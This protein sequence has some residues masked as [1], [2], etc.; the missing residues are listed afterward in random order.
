MEK[1]LLIDGHSILNRAY[2]GIPTLTNKDGLH[3]NA[4]YGFLNILF[5]ILDE[6]K[7]EYLTVCF[8]VH[9]P[10]FRHEMFP[11][12]K[13]NRKGMD[14]ELREQVPVIQELLRAMTVDVKTLEGYE[15]DDIIGTLSKQAEDKGFSVS[16]VSG[17]RDLLQLT[18]NTTKL[19]IPKTKRSGTEIEEYFEKDVIEKY[20]VTP[21]EF[22]DV[23]AL[24]GDSS[25]N[26]PGVAGIGEKGAQTLISEYHSIENA[27]EHLEEIKQKRTREALRENY[28]MGL[29]CKKLAAINRTS[30]V[31]FNEKESLIGDFYTPEAFEIIKRL[32]FKKLLERFSGN[33]TNP[34]EDKVRNVKQM[35]EISA[36][37]GEVFVNLIK[38]KNEITGI[39]ASKGD[40]EAL[41]VLFED[42]GEDEVKKALKT[43]I[44]KAERFISCD[45]KSVLHFAF[46]GEELPPFEEK[47]GDVAL[48]SYLIN[49][50][51]GKYV[52]ESAEEAFEAY[53]GFGDTLK[54]LEEKGMK[55]LYQKMEMP[56]VFVLC[57]MEKEGIMIKKD[58]LLAYGQKLSERIDVLEKEIHEKA[59]EEFNIL[60]PKQLGTVLFEKMG[61]KG[62]KKTKTGYSTAADVLEKL[63]GDYPIVNKILEYRQLTKLKST[64]ADA[65]LGYADEG[66]RIHTV[67]NQTVTATG[68]LSSS[69]PN[70][71]NI[72]IRM[73]LGRE[74]RKVFVPKEGYCF[75]DADYSQIEL[76][77]LAHLSGD[78]KLIEAYKSAQD[79][80][81]LT[82]SWVFG[83]PFDEVTD[84]QRRNAKAVNFGII[85][86][87]SSFGL[88]EDLGIT[89]KEAAKYMEQYF[90]TYPAIKGYLDSL[91]ESAKETGYAKTMFGRIRP[92]PEIKS[93][94][95][96]QRS[97]GERV[98]MNAP[99]QGTAADII[100]IAMIN[101]YNRLKKENL[102]SRLLL[103][104]HD[105]LLIETA[106]DETDEVRK[107]LE[108]EMEG[109]A[110]L[111]VKLEI[112]V[113][114]GKNWQEAH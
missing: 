48:A 91:V 37:S 35:A 34:I 14:E 107:I 66:S 16:I 81:R 73:E 46:D 102:K 88:S 69:D 98:A 77:V 33:V 79:I 39:V 6:E 42:V 85:Y 13:G 52:Y 7:P 1:Y 100:K 24:Q 114:E 5:K 40:K 26:F 2:Y 93:S 58:E 99:I 15:A 32:E 47:Y 92:L 22:I 10:T 112:D 78:E 83:V 71:Q 21:T 53:L 108:E 89:R 109:A 8:D 65:L 96:M 38:N 36:F 84:L 104:V 82:A 57:D 86:G 113:N 25:D 31:E 68:R 17:D 62:G 55:E 72:P 63:A 11:D 50:L 18:S 44:L 90:E 95:F 101:V 111:S 54:E 94:N 75:L 30:P 80:H 45:L 76:R 49:P 4:V 51:K 60:S 12:Y 56:L 28:E 87:M 70:L 9:A 110:E 103:Q 67:F 20:H 23:K 29:L 106:E 43:I 64:Y 59:G 74:I 3:T 61:I 105:E 97:F 19:I 41:S 27:Y